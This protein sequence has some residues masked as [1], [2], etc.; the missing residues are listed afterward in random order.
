[1]IFWD[2]FKKHQRHI[3]SGGGHGSSSVT[4]IFAVLQTGIPSSWILVILTVLDSVPSG[5]LT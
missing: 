2:I 4:V 5:K 1:V 3:S